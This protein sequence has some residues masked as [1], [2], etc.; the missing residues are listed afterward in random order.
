MTEPQDWLYY[1]VYVASVGEIRDLVERVVA[2]AITRFTA[3]VPRLRWFFLQYVDA[4]GLQLRLRLY[5]APEP[6]AWM[7][8]ELDE[9]FARALDDPRTVGGPH[10]S[11]AARRMAV[12]RLYEPEYTK[13]GGPQGLQLA[14]DLL[15]LG[16]ETALTCSVGPGRRERRVTV[17]AA[18]TDLMVNELPAEH[19]TPFLHQ[20]AWYWSGRGRQDAPW[21]GRGP[22][23]TPEEPSAR[24]RAGRLR[25]QI[26][27]LVSDAPLRDSLTD[28]VHR[29]W[30][31]ARTAE[32]GHSDYVTAFQ[33]IHLMNNRLG[34]VPSEERQIARL[35]WLEKV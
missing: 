11:R 14:E 16:S 7:E 22:A 26:A 30:R 25:S 10:R 32:G 18:H 21:A 15:Q 27:D 23:L 12:K 13:F 34:V 24:R 2:P 6:L 20:Y 29:F 28:Y 8:R 35:L 4:V 5:A 19:R 1:R 17:G 31:Q 9:E 33:H 3:A